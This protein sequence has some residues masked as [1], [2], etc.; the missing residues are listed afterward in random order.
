MNKNI[1]KNPNMTIQ[2]LFDLLKSN[3][4]EAS[5]ILWELTRYD[6]TK[7][8]DYV[9]IEN[10]TTYLENSGCKTQPQEVIDYMK[11][12]YELIDVESEIRNVVEI[13]ES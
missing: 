2:E 8:W 5:D 6:N 4:E 3:S 9:G 11:D 12:N 1:I 13:L 10:A 7:A